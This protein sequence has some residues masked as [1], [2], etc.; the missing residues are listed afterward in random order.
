MKIG[1][2]VANEFGNPLQ[3]G[4]TKHVFKNL[5]IENV[6][7]IKLYAKYYL[8]ISSEKVVNNYMGFKGQG[9]R[10]DFGNYVAHESD[11]AS[12]ESRLLGVKLEFKE[13][14]TSFLEFC[15][16]SDDIMFSKINL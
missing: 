15:Q 8:D 1:I 9:F 7:D 12:P 16:M 11:Y 13:S 2:K 4:Q 5:F 3:E 14:E 10:K 6:E